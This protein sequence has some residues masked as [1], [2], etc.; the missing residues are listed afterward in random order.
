MLWSTCASCKPSFGSLMNSE[1]G[2]AVTQGSLSK[3]LLYSYFQ[4]CFFCHLPISKFS[5]IFQLLNGVSFCWPTNRQPE[6][7]LEQG[8]VKH[9]ITPPYHILVLGFGHLWLPV[10]TRVTVL[11]VPFIWHTE[12]YRS[13]QKTYRVCWGSKISPKCEQSWP[14]SKK[15][16]AFQTILPCVGCKFSPDHPPGWRQLTSAARNS[17]GHTVLWPS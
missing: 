4:L 13:C 2:H 15:A 10:I 1:M 14:N 8:L 11:C 7:M 17:P 3:P 6:R 5:V 16:T 12:N 9:K